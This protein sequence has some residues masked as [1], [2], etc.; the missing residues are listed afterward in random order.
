MTHDLLLNVFKELGAAVLG[1]SVVSLEDGTYYAEIRGPVGETNNRID[2]RP[3]TPSRW[4]C[5][6]AR[7]SG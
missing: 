6:P 4:R 5:V 1:V 7:P 2:S 3:P